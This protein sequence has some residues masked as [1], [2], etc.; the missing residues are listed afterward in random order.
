MNT[1]LEAT[2]YL[3]EHNTNT[4]HTSKSEQYDTPVV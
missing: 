4:Q 1:F 3:Q 2:G